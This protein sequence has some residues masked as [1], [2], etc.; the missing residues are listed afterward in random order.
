MATH[1][2]LVSVV[3]PTYNHGHFLKEAIQSLLLQT[4][5]HWEALIINNYSEDNTIEVVEQF[6]EPRIKLVNFR[7]HG[8]IAASRNQGIRRAKGEYIAFLDSDDV[9][10]PTKLDRCVDALMSGCSLVCHGTI[11][12]WENGRTRNVVHGPEK[13]ASYQALLYHGNRLATS[14][15]VVRKNIVEEVGGFNTEPSFVTAEDYD[16]WLR[17][18]KA[19]HQ[20]CF[21]PGM[22]GEYRIHKDNASRV[23][24]GRDAALAVLDHHFALDS[25][26]HIFHQFKQRKRRSGVVSANAWAL[27]NMGDYPLAVNEF[28]RALKMWPLN[29]KAYAAGT[30]TV[31]RWAVSWLSRRS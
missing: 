26:R 6:N 9:W 31:A 1:N 2:S 15:T 22:L 12:R 20:F 13:R 10:K 7:N 29:W 11:W 14:A 4:Y 5:P 16:L 19:G 30:L 23:G 3:V 27:R 28:R 18:A 25:R 24:I 8:V 21:I 17:I